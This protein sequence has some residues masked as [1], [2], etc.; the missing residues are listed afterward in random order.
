MAQK[1]LVVGRGGRRKREDSADAFL[2]DPEGGRAS[3]SDEVAEGMAEDFLRSATSG[4]EVWDERGDEPLPEEIEGLFVA[5]TGDEE[6]EEDMEGSDE[7]FETQAEIARSSVAA[8]ATLP[9]SAR[10]RVIGPSR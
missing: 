10:R 3:T 6:D 5:D 1:N 9:T 8:P 4:E 7:R 2:R